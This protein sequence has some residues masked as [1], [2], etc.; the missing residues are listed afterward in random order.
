MPCARGTAHW[1]LGH[2][3]VI[4]SSDLGEG[5]P[6]LTVKALLAVIGAKEPQ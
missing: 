5:L 3:P 1:T 6:G 2:M 4:I